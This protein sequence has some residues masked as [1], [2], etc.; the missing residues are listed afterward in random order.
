MA[1]Y[2]FTPSEM[3][4]VVYFP[5]FKGLNL[6]F[7]DFQDGSGWLDLGIQQWSWP[8]NLIAP[9]IT[10]QNAILS[11]SNNHGEPNFNINRNDRNK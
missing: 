5:S 9:V 1:I 7:R 4:G 10:S 2:H 6:S 8:S 11:R 3:I